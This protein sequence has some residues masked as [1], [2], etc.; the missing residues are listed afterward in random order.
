MAKDAKKK[1]Q[2]PDFPDEEYNKTWKDEKKY[3]YI[4]ESSDPRF[5][6]VTI[7]KNHENGEII[8]SKEK[9]ASSK[10]EATNDILNLQSRMKL[11]NQNMLE[12]IGY[13]TK[14]QKALCSTSYLSRGFYK[15]PNTDMKRELKDHKKDLK[16]F[17]SQELNNMH[18]QVNGALNS[19]HSK[20]L[21]HDDI[22][23][24]LIGKNKQYNLY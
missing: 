10:K 8:F 18:N 6:T 20:N 24:Q 1:T 13:S 4:R 7:L 9:V 15:F 5:G 11:N 17:S 22:R 2:Q 21:T 19:L 14:I 16:D 12:M 3:K 23:P